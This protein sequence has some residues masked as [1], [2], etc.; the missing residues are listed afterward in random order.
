MNISEVIRDIDSLSDLYRVEVK[1]SKKPDQYS[2]AEITEKL[3]YETIVK[4]GHTNDLLLKGFDFKRYKSD[5]DY[6]WYDELIKIL[7]DLEGLNKEERDQ[8][9]SS[10]L[11]FFFGYLRFK[12]KY[13]DFLYNPQ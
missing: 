4:Y 13:A 8:I 7:N 9:V 11:S 3:A 12:L 10:D 6:I 1:S 2:D 5:N